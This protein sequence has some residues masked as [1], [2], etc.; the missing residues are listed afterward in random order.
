MRRAPAFLAGARFRAIKEAALERRLR[1]EPYIHDSSQDRQAQSDLSGQE[2]ANGHLAHSLF[3][4]MKARY[5]SARA[6]R[7][8]KRKKFDRPY[9]NFIL[10]LFIH[11]C[12]HLKGYE[13]GVQWRV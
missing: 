10:F 7:A 9:A 6:R 3:Q 8:K 11:G 12:V 4:R 13:H 5:T 1:F 2:N